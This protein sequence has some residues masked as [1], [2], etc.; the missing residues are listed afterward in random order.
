MAR[1]HLDALAR[2][3][4]HPAG[5]PLPRPALRPQYFLPRFSLG[6]LV[7]QLIQV[8][9]FAHCLFFDVFHA[10]AA[11]DAFNQGA[12]RIR[13]RRLLEEGLPIGLLVELDIELILTV[14]GQPANDFID[15]GFGA[16]LP[17]RLGD[18]MGVDNGEAHF[19]DPVV[20]HG[21]L[22]GQRGTIWGHGATEGTAQRDTGRIALYSSKHTSNLRNELWTIVCKS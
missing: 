20:G 10:D 17:L 22:P 14:S 19:V 8:A 13:V 5:G 12:R 6:Q 2:P 7:D 18:I 15:F 4:C 1:A 9:D 11:E 3:A 16:S 21:R